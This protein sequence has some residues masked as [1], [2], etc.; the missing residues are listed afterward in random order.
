[1]PDSQS[2]SLE[3]LLESIKQEYR[4]DRG[5][6]LRTEQDI[7]EH[8]RFFF[9]GQ[10]F[11]SHTAADHEFCKKHI[12]PVLNAFGPRSYFFMSIAS[13]TPAIVNA[14]RFMVQYSLFYCK[15]VIFA[16]SHASVQSEWVRLEATWTVEQRH[17]RILCL[18]DETKPEELHLE[19][20]HHCH[21]VVEVPQRF[22]RFYEDIPA[23]QVKL[24]QILHLPEFAI[25]KTDNS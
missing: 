22:I 23:A 5:A 17:P 16:L 13:T 7:K 3:N 20:G 2:K 14:Y 25:D 21:R 1:V 11:L 12:V 18:L 24:G 4:K 6:S 9:E 8:C 19:F 10:L 15:T